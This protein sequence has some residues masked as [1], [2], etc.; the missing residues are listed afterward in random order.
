[1]STPA[2]RNRVNRRGND[3]GLFD[4]QLTADGVVVKGADRGRLND[5][6]PRQ[7]AARSAAIASR[8][9]STVSVCD[10]T[11]SRPIP[12]DALYVVSGP[13]ERRLDDVVIAPR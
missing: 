5:V 1:M 11:A 8:H 9:T 7:I 2:A 12:A 13:W 3:F 10:E 6:K 4:R